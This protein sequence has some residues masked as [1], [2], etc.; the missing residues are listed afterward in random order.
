M[1]N[2]ANLTAQLNL[3]IQNFSQNLRR[4]SAQANQ[5]ASTLSGQINGGLVDPAKKAKFEFKDVSRIVQGIIISKVFY[6]GLNAIRQCTDAVWEFAQQLEY[7][8]IAYSNLFGDTALANEFINVLK[9]FAAKTPFSFT[10]SEQAAKRLL[11]YGIQYKNVMYVMQGVMSAAAMQNDPAK[12]E[13]I[14]RALG[15][16]YTKG[17]LMNEELRQLAEAGIPAYEILREKLQLTDDQ[18]KNIGKTAIPASVAINALVDGMNERFGN[19]VEAS[20]RTMTG[21]ISNIKDNAT[22]LFAGLF[23]PLVQS[24]KSALSSLGELLF[25]LREIFELKGAGGVFEA[26]FPPELHSTIR[27]FIANLMNL[28]TVIKIHL[29]NAFEVLKWAVYGLVVAFNAIAPVVT[30]VLD[31]LGRMIQMLVQNTTFMKILTGAL[32]AAATAWVIFKVKALGALVLTSVTKVIVGLSK[33]ILF[34]AGALLAHPIITLFTLLAAGIVGVAVASS[35]ASSKLSEFFKKLT[36]FNGVDPDKILLPSQKERANDLDKF[37]EKLDGTADSMD[38][39]ADSTGKATKAAK[40]LLSFDEVFKLNEPKDENTQTPDWGDLEATMPDLGIDGDAFIPEIPDFGN[41]ATDFVDKMF[42]AL[43]D[44]ILSAGIGAL[45]GGLLGYL[46]GGPL[47]AAL[48]ALAGGIVGYFWDEIAKAIGLSDNQKVAVPLAAFLG[49]A[50]GAVIGGPLGALI[51]GAIGALVGWIVGAI[52]DGFETGDWDYSGIGTAI[53]TL[54]GAGIGALLGGPIGA[55]VGGAI[56]TLVGWVTGKIVEGFQTGNWDY[57]GIGTGIGLGVGAGIGYLVGGP[58]GALI[59]GAIG[60][61]VGWVTG[62]IVEGFQ[63]GN[64]N[65]TGIST[66][67]GTGIGAAIGMVAGG[68]VGAAIGAAVGALVGWITGLI[69]DNWDSITNWFSEVFSAIGDFFSDLGENLAGLWEN[70]STSVSTWVSQTWDTFTTWLGN[71]GPMLRDGFMNMMHDIGYALG[72]G[73]GYI[74]K[75]FVDAGKA[76]ISFFTETLPAAWESFKEAWNNFWSV[77]FPNVLS[78]IGQFFVNAGKKFLAFFTETIPAAWNSFKD[79]WNNFW[80]VT[81]PSVLSSIGQ[82]FVDAGKAFVSFFTETI[83]NAWNSFKEGWNNFWSVTFPAALDNIGTFFQGLWNTFTEWGKNI[84]DGFIQGFK[85]AWDFVWEA[86]SEFFNGFIEG[87]KNVFG[88]HSPATSTEPLGTNVILGFIQG[89]VGAVGTMLETIAAIGVQVISAIG[90]W[91]VDIGTNIATW[92][93]ETATSIVN[94]ASNTAT[95]IATWVSNRITDFA[96]WATTTATNIGS[97]VTDTAGRI[98]GWV[99]DTTGKFAN[100]VSTSISKF[101]SFVS[102]TTGKVANWATTTTA[103]IGNWVSTNAAKI[104]SFVSTAASKFASFVSDGIA[105]F[106]NF[107]SN[108]I[109]KIGGWASNMASKASSAMSNFRSQVSSGLS[110]ALSSIGNFCS[111]ALSKISSWASSFGSWIS[112]TISSAASAV[113]S[114]VSSVGSRISGAVSSAKSFVFGG[115]ATGG[116]FNREHIARF[117]E[118]NKAEAVIPLENASAMQPFVDAVSQGLAQTLGPI[119]TGM[120]VGGGAGGAGGQQLQP[121]YVGTLIADERSLRELQRK[122]QV[123]QLQE[124]TRRGF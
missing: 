82:F 114:F 117:A 43:K 45:L 32:M 121:L 94:W 11:A 18:I 110:S 20:S 103:N 5:F 108:T 99:S 59:G 16:V 93:A 107:A 97:W 76:F 34:L 21:I 64:W 95:T 124:D 33:A 7:A 96:N 17:R 39:L 102:D 3:N 26:L 23:D 104:G 46:L 85:G 79:G 70:I 2:F 84:I 41:F 47:G 40:G 63:T 50:I 52:I 27:T 49:A 109:S 68:P 56:G 31:V 74:A 38:K 15:Q 73:L 51:G 111:N 44:K 101:G 120:S 60:T 12:V 112:N 35:G 86:I 100:W 123:I 53:G 24:I 98:G 9:D 1:A 91:F 58:I 105:K 118:G 13:Q 106:S 115:H 72:T 55:L 119:F 71:L 10:E 88:I 83:P 6:G 80:S 61:L 22:M 25:T 36:S 89:M 19:V 87:F 69:I 75:F 122:M 30:A 66:G 78:S 42:G 54:I 81:F 29:S 57:T 4:A 77:T 28:W 8:Q 62:A 65:V 48:G 37:N 92:S 113:S 90:Q 116:I 14:S 67:I